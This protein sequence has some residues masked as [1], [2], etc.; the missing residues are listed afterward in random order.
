MKTISRREVEGT[1][2]DLRTER[3]EGV[4]SGLSQDRDGLPWREIVQGI[5]FAIAAWV[6]WIIAYAAFVIY[7]QG[8]D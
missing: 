7:V 5:L 8:G 4:E 1:V 2:P 6:I 3:S